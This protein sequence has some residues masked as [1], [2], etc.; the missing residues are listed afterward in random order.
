MTTIGTEQFYRPS[1]T[2]P[3]QQDIDNILAHVAWHKVNTLAGDWQPSNPTISLTPDGARY[4]PYPDGQAAGGSVRHLALNGQPFAAITNLAFNIN[5]TEDGLHQEY[6]PYL[7]VFLQDPQGAAHDAIYTPGSQLYTGQGCGPYQ[8]FVASQG[9]WRYDSDDG[10]G[11]VPLAELQAQY[12]DHTITKLTITLGYTG[13][14]NLTGLLR[15]WEIN[16]NYYLFCAATDLV[17][18]TTEP[19]TTPT[20]PTT[21]TTAR[22]E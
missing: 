14:A 15:W 22:G 4:G 19:A 2:V 6:S 18:A 20:T 1:T 16:S 8:E 21:P 11:G 12:A 3:T 9:M 5:Y 7:R 10:T 13:G 17:T